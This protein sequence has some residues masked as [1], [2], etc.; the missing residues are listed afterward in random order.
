MYINSGIIVL[1]LDSCE[2]IT[3]LTIREILLVLYL[4]YLF[5]SVRKLYTKYNIEHRKNKI[6]ILYLF[7]GVK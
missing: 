3:S 7:S 6:Q 4:L 2:F 5:Q 1:I